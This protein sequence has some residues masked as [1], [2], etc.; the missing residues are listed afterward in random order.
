[1]EPEAF[2]LDDLS[3]DMGGAEKLRFRVFFDFEGGELAFEVWVIADSLKNSSRVRRALGSAK[4][5]ESGTDCRRNSGSVSKASG[6]LTLGA[7]GRTA[8]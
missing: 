7:V 2:E 3:H 4:R 8:S 6:S 5:T 1:L